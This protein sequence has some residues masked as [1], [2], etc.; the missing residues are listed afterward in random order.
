MALF[1][2]IHDDNCTIAKKPE[3]ATQDMDA[4]D[5]EQEA[6]WFEQY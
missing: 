3:P 2:G 4:S 5:T 6:R 1:T